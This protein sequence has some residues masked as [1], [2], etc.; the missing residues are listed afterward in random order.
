MRLRPTPLG[1][2]FRI[3]VARAA[4]ARS[5]FP[6]ALAVIKMRQEALDH[7]RLTRFAGDAPPI[8]GAPLNS[9]VRNLLRARRSEG[10]QRLPT[11]DTQ[12]VRGFLTG[13]ATSDRPELA[14]ALRTFR[15]IMLTTAT[16]V[17]YHRKSSA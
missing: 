15:P 4:G 5:A 12:K 7:R 16:V 10:A 3:A 11:I 6:C 14:G 1:R 17:C 9:N 13:S 2:A 8:G